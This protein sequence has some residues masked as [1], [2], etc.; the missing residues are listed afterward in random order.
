MKIPR[1]A[2]TFNEVTDRDVFYEGSKTF[3]LKYRIEDLLEVRVFNGNYTD[4]VYVD[5]DIPL[6]EFTYTKGSYQITNIATETVFLAGDQLLV[7]LKTPDATIAVPYSPDI[8]LPPAEPEPDGSFVYPVSFFGDRTD[9]GMETY[10]ATSDRFQVSTRLID[11]G[12]IY[13]D[14]NVNALDASKLTTFMNTIPANSTDIGLLDWETKIFD[15]LLGSDAV[16][17]EA[18]REVFKQTI[19][20]AKAARSNIRLGWYNL[21]SNF[22]YSSSNTTRNRP[23]GRHDEV[24][25][26]LD[27]LV[28]SLYIFNPAQENKGYFGKTGHEANKEYIRQVLTEALT[29]KIRTGKP[30][31]PI[32]WHMVHISNPIYK[33]QA[34]SPEEISDLVRVAVTHE[35]QGIKI[36]GII[37]WDSMGHTSTNQGGVGGWCPVCRTDTDYTNLLYKPIMQAILPVLTQT[38]LTV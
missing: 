20:T 35:V 4:G 16:K 8:V 9:L 32:M 34:L 33:N 3:S 21:P 1:F 7:R 17:A 23:L 24:L 5:Q 13:Q 11:Q 18:A 22:L 29:T 12:N 14:S 15:D 27:V 30:V 38:P 36:D 37:W 2:T 6:E 28:P 25:N 26:L 19:T 10:L 31:W